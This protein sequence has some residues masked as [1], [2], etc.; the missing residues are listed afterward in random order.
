MLQPGAQPHPSSLRH[1]YG[2]VCEVTVTDLSILHPEPARTPRRRRRRRCRVRQK[3]AMGLVP[4]SLTPPEVV[5]DVKNDPQYLSGP[6]FGNN[7]HHHNALVH[8][9]V[10][11]R[12]R[13]ARS[14][15]CCCCFFVV[16][17]V[18]VSRRVVAT[19]ALGFRSRHKGGLASARTRRCRAKLICSKN[20]TTRTPTLSHE[21]V[22]L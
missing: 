3:G 2:T 12:H 19:F 20:W 21:L 14:S 10:P 9:S 5:L 18:A 17:I 7:D 15:F 22:L 4:D 13:I 16:V 8:L 1:G 11:T 6:V